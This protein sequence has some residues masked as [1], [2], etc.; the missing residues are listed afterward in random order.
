MANQ[1]VVATLQD[2]EQQW[3]KDA[4]ISQ[5]D[6]A[7]TSMRTGKLH[8][9]YYR[10][11]VQEKYGLFELE[12]ELKRLEYNLE[13]LYQ[14]RLVDDDYDRLGWEPLD[15]IPPTAA[16]RTKAVAIDQRMLEMRSKMLRQSLK[17][18]ALKDII[19]QINGRQW[20]IRNTLEALKWE[21]GG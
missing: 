18:D 11:M 12:E 16:E 8:W 17:V 20:I 2:I 5:T 19:T 10:I 1:V 14:G 4:V 9:K 3:E 21:S 7:E 6:L 13:L 15:K